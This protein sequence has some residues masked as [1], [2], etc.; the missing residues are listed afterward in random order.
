MEHNCAVLDGWDPTLLQWITD[1][2]V[3]AT[4]SNNLTVEE[5]REPIQD[6]YHGSSLPLHKRSPFNLVMHLGELW[7]VADLAE[8]LDTSG[9][10]WVLLMAPP[11]RLT[12]A[13]VWPLTP[14]KAVE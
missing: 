4:T 1:S 10:P 5:V 6:G 8:W 9:R 14:V 2:G 7:L 3:A 11:M 12:E 13:V